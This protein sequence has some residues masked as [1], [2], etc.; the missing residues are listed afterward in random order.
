MLVF[1]YNKSCEDLIR[2]TKSTSILKGGPSLRHFSYHLEMLWF[3]VPAGKEIEEPKKK[4]ASYVVFSA[5][6]YVYNTISDD[7]RQCDFKRYCR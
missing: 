1:C 7:V 5:C 4:N 6:F 3:R 2:K